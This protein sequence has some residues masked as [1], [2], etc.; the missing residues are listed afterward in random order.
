MPRSGF[1][2]Y[3]NALWYYIKRA[4]D[5]PHLADTRYHFSHLF[6]PFAGDLPDDR[7][8][9][10]L[11]H[12]ANRTARRRELYLSF[13]NFSFCGDEGDVFGN[14][15]AIVLGLAGDARAQ[16]VMRALARARVADPFPARSVCMPIASRD[17]L[18]R[19]YMTRH[20][21]N[22]EHQ[23]HNGGIWP[24]LGGFYVMARA[25]LGDVEGARQ[26][27]A[28]LAYANSLGNWRFSE[29]FHGQSLMPMGMAGQSWNAAAFL[30]ARQSLRESVF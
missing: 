10:L 21:Q 12:Y 22:L 16:R 9:R 30:L 11:A 2:L 17:D 15:L 27:L 8:A 20:R 25:G 5:L 26:A 14:L 13:V 23:Y 3:S 1:V 4:F 29:W 28:R 6:Y 19:A 18:W 7:R 24:M